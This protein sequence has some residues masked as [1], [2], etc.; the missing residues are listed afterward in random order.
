VFPATKDKASNANQI[1]AAI[2]AWPIPTKRYLETA[3]DRG[4]AVKFADDERAYTELE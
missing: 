1:A 4:D 3:V 2:N